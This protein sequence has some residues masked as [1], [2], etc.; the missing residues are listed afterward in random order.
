MWVSKVGDK[1][2]AWL[3]IQ[4]GFD[5]KKSISPKLPGCPEWCPATHF[6]YLQSG[7]MGVI[8]K[9][10]TEKTIKA[11]ES[12]LIPPG[13]LPVMNEDA[14]MVEFS[15]DTTYTADIKK[16]AAKEP[17]KEKERTTSSSA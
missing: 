13:H 10:G 12:Y 14:V 1:Q 6:G 2:F 11:G 9:D 17:A 4:K 7:T 3:K 16:P 5:W 8:M 15:Q